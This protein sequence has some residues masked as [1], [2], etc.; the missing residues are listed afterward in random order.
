MQSG[1]VTPNV[2]TH[3]FPSVTVTV[4]LVPVVTD[5][6][7]HTLPTVFTTEPAVLETVPALTVTCSEYERRSG[8]HVGPDVNEIVGRVLTVAE[9]VAVIGPLQPVAVAVTVV[10]PLQ[11]DE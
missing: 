2:F 6:M 9:C 3:P 1:D 4:I 5:E 8:A 11:V 7:V 10:T